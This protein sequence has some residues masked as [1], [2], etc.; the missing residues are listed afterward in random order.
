MSGRFPSLNG[1]RAVSILLVL[2]SHTQYIVGPTPAQS[3]FFATWLDGNLGVRF[4]FSISGFLI[5]WLM[6]VEETEHKGVGLKNFYIRRCLRIWPVYFSFV[7]VVLAFQLSGFK[8]QSAESWRGLLTFTRNFY[9]L[10]AGVHSDFLT[11]HIW[12]LSVEEQFYVFWPLAFC[13]LGNCGRIVILAFAICL[14]VAFRTIGVLGLY[15]RHLDH[16][17][18][19]NDSTFNYL[20]CIGWGCLG[21][22][23]LARN[24][25]KIQAFT[26]TNSTL[27]FLT[28]ASMVLI[29]YLAQFGKGIQ[30]VGFIG[31]ILHSVLCPDW[32]FYRLLNRPW[33][34]RI[35]ILSYSLYV[36]QE[37]VW[38]LWPAFLGKVWVLWIPMTFGIAWVSYNVLETPFFSLRSKFRPMAPT[39]SQPTSERNADGQE[40]VQYS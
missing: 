6:L 33:M 38:Y 7:A 19:Q 15:D 24:K 17:L 3:H 29:P 28:C 20:D 13:F 22:F 40:K 9:D 34:E 32:A 25:L 31:L 2:G 1:W 39:R 10:N 5:T 27:V 14:S 21:A 8:S 18:F 37:L 23:A 36:W 35:G 12:S 26:K 30:A 16:F 4:F 11:T